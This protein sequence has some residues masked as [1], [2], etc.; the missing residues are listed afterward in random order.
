M[1]EA[2]TWLL[3]PTLG[4]LLLSTPEARCSAADPDRP[5]IL[6]LTVEDMSPTLG[7]WGDAY[8]HTPHIDGLASQSVRYTRAFATAPVCSPS[9]SCLITGCYATTLGTQ[10]LRSAFPIP[11]YIRGFPEF[12]R[13]RGYYCTNN[14]KTDYNTSNASEIIKTSWDEC[15]GKAHWRNRKSRQPFFAIFNDMTS[16][17]SRT[18]VWPYE[19]FQRDVQSRLSPDE[20]HDPKEAPVPPYYPETPLIRKTVARYYDCISVMDKNVGRLLQQLEE[21]GLADD[22]I[23][24]FYSDHGSGMPRHKRALLDSGMHVPLLIRF[25]PK[26]QHL[27]PAKPGEDVDRLV[28]FVDFAPTVLSLLGISVPDYIQGVPFLG[29]QA[30]ER[31]QFVYGA[32]D[33]V[34]EVFDLARSVRSDKYLYIRNYM[35]HLSY[36]QPSAWPDEGQFRWEFTREARKGPG[37]LTPPQWHYLAPTRPLEELY[38][39]ESDPQNLHSLADSPEHRDTLTTMREELRRRITETRDLGFLPEAEVWQRCAGTTPYEI[40]RNVKLH[41][42]QRL[43]EAASLVGSGESTLD[44]LIRLLKDDDCAVRYWAAVGLAALA[45]KTAPTRSAL[46][47]ATTDASFTVRIEAANALA[48]MGDVETALPVL[49]RSLEHDDPDTMLHAARTIELLGSKAQSAVP[50]MRAALKRAQAG[51]GRYMFVRFSTQAFLKAISK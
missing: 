37:V 12:L 45:E 7:C 36:H 5:N 41:P 22:T 15:S 1:R 46:L 44:E 6:W 13:Q 9:R 20:I 51:G 30:G 40:A 29:T 39:V 50:S 35:P 42:Q 26:Y 32:R 18:M 24:F 2:M 16:H 33:R 27:A 49:I 4:T 21:D 25:P 48:R 31:R 14:V 10:R 17:Q 8:A 3:L 43:I 11:D 23:V 19:Q 34:D 28:S 47:T 38:D